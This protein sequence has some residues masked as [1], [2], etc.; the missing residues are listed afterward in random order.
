MERLRDSL[1]EAVYA[2]AQVREI[3][4]GAIEGLRV[5]GYELMCRAG[6]AALD[7]L[8]R[9]WPEARKIVVYCGAGN[10]A[11]DGYVLA[12]LARAAGLAVRVEAVTPP[13]RLGGDARR[14]WEDCSRAGVAAEPFA[15]VSGPTP[16]TPDIVVDA[17]LGTGLTR[18]VEGRF[19]EAVEHIN[20]SRAPVL[21]LDVPSG[22]DADTGWPLGCAVR[23]AVTVTFVGLKQGIFLGAGPDHTGELEFSDLGLPSDLSGALAPAFRRLGPATLR[24][25][26]PPR[27]RTAHKGT[28]GR[29]LVV[30]GA[31]GTAG[32][33]RLTAE[34]ALRVGAGLVYVA[35]DKDSVGTVLAG[36]PE[37]MCR[38]VSRAQDLDPLLDLADGVVLGPGLGQSE[39][40][41]ALWHRVVAADL[42]LVVD[43]D[44]LNLLA[45]LGASQRTS[46]SGW[47]LTPHPG[48]AGRLLGS[49]AGA[50]Q[51]DRLAA[52]RTLATRYVATAVLKGA[53]TLVATADLDVRVCD[54][55]NPGMGTAGVGD[56]LSGVLGGLLVQLR[57]I[58][59]TARA[60]VLL[61]ALA[62]DDAAAEGERGLVA[63]D[64]MPALRRWANPR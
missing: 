40:S 42:P 25:A 35:T 20:A 62:G 8:R 12:R 44:A 16:F 49:D 28:N 26:L 21:A 56:V 5:A 46:R 2:A 3:D 9:R 41:R 57:E 63:G 43:A 7:V 33:I 36:R 61:H 1:P 58:P 48:E 47:L 64:L 27:A 39:W 37:L 30:G 18:A 31:P 13:E 45:E 55:G 60:G 19:A 38:P 59:M 4:R 50:V 14:A 29:L 51:R 32:A 34:A 11:G 15:A 23:A 53:C 54:Y 24:A 22:L 10:N 6:R 17:L 52:V